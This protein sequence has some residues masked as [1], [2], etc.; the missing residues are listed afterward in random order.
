LVSD[1]ETVVA[2]KINRI[3][4]AIYADNS[5]PRDILISIRLAD[6][7]QDFYLSSDQVVGRLV[8]PS[9]QW[10]KLEKAISIINSAL[11]RAGR[12]DKVAE[13]DFLRRLSRQVRRTV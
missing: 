5:A 12:H 8:P 4:S 10:G 13:E 9:E 3:K 1:R 11:I 7:I 2:E 6:L